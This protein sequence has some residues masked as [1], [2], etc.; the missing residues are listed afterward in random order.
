MKRHSPEVRPAAPAEH[1]WFLP[2]AAA[3]LALVGAA[4]ARVL[5]GLAGTDMVHFTVV[6][7][8][9]PGTGVLLGCMLLPE[10][11]LIKI[12]PRTI[13]EVF[14]PFV[15][16][17]PFL[18][19][20]LSINLPIA[21]AAAAGLTIYRGALLGTF[22]GETARKYLR[23]L[24]F[25]AAAAGVLLIALGVFASSCAY[26]RMFLTMLDWG[27]YAQTAWRT[28]HG[29]ILQGT[30]PGPNFS[31]GHFMPGYFFLLAPFYGLLPS[32]CTVF[33]TGALALWGSAGLLY[34]FA[35][36]RGF[37]R[38]CSAAF[39]LVWLLC[40]SVS[41]LNLTA[42]YGINAIV[43][44]IPVFFGFY[45]LYEAKRYRLAFLVFLFSLTLK[46]TVG[47]FWLGWGMVSFLEKRRRDGILYGVIGTAWFLLCM[48]VFIPHF[49][50]GEYIFYS[51]FGQLGG[52]ILE[53]LLS[54][55]TRPAEFWG[56]VFR[57][58]NLQFIL[59][60][61]LPFFPGALN[62]PWLLGAGAI[63]I[64]FNFIRGSESI[65]NLVHQYQVETI[66][67]F[68]VALVLG[69][70]RVRADGKL[71]RLL[72]W[73][74]TGARRRNT[75]LAM[76]AGTVG[77]ALFS[78]LFF[79][80]SFYGKN[81]LDRL[82]FFS[83]VRG[84]VAEMEQLIPPGEPIS[85]GISAAPQFL[86][87]NTVY[88][89]ERPEGKF[90]VYHIG[91]DPMGLS[92][93]KHRKFLQDP[94]LTLLRTKLLED[95]RTLFLFRRGGAA[96]PP[97]DG[98]ILPTPPRHLSGAR[99]FPIEDERGVRFLTASIQP[100]GENAR[101]VFRL[102][103]PLP[104]FARIRFQLLFPD[105]SGYFRSFFFADAAVLPEHTRIGT[106]YEL[107]LPFPMH[108]LESAQPAFELRFL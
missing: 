100:D 93:E 27:V 69:V 51:Q 9:W 105:G 81:N 64:G 96:S 97:G 3:L 23:R 29:H 25:F 18:P 62:R 73:K 74:L 42:F 47:I 68:A 75:R 48:K 101:V 94:E 83:N 31:E 56:Q 39:G 13:L 55:F 12:R 28:F 108:E 10:L 78:H 20:A 1:P 38:P 30:W 53:I 63:L 58:K 106:G 88:G 49:A 33:V 24:P 86:F 60:L 37:S 21:Y 59:L 84:T 77:C 70:R 87:R 6:G 45:M 17:L 98:T 16:T 2:A 46:E 65:V 90:L 91:E 34:L 61:L 54:P 57:L 15:L 103:R 41:N 99:P 80:E 104:G 32:V 44:F 43:F 40:P 14:A 67:M 11:L 52:G 4:T 5:F 36:Q 72:R 107:P 71:A 7:D 85:A 82:A 26:D 19:F 102:L 79:A 95:G 92:L 76:I 66:A 50:G 35:R 89:E 22:D 8:E